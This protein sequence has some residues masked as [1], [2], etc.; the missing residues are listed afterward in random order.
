MRCCEQRIKQLRAWASKTAWNNGWTEHA[1]RWDRI[2][3]LL[4]SDR[5]AGG[6]WADMARHLRFA[7]PH[8]LRDI[9][10]ADW[11]SVRQA[12]L[13]ATF[14]GEPLAVRVA[15]LATLVATAPSGPVTT[16]VDW[17]VLDPDGFERVV[18]EILRS[19]RSYENSERLMSTNASDKGRDLSTVRVVVDELSRNPTNSD[20]GPVQALP[21]HVSEPQRMLAD[22]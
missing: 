10:D 9:I 6:R 17:S 5:P 21:V 11:P 7:E 19:S 8:D 3:R 16:A 18:L 13:D 1:T 14:A 2:H 22:R 4:G 20:D 15:D 12:I